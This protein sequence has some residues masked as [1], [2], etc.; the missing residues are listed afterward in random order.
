MSSG[1]G[2]ADHF[3]SDSTAKDTTEI[4][5]TRT[6]PTFQ[7]SQTY[8]GESISS[9]TGSSLEP[10]S[11][12]RGNLVSQ[13]SSSA[14]HDMSPSS[15][16][17]SART[18]GSLLVRA[19]SSTA[20]LFI[21]RSPSE[22][23][24]N[25]RTNRPVMM[26]IGRSTS[27]RDLYGST[28]FGDTDKR[29]FYDDFT[30]VDWVHDTIN[31]SSR[32][33]YLQ[34]LDGLR[35]KVIRSMDGLQ[36]WV[37]IVIVAFAFSLIAYFIDTFDARF[38]DLKTGYCSANPFNDLQTCCPGNDSASSCAA[39]VTWSEVFEGTAT[40]DI[41]AVD[42]LV[43]IA[44][45][46]IFAYV[47]V[48]LTL[49]TKT[50]NPLSEG[51]DKNLASSSTTTSHLT[52]TT[53]SQHHVKRPLEE[54]SLLNKEK[55]V[56]YSAYGSG[57]PEVKII[58]S[59]FIIRKFLGTRT[60]IIKTIALVFAISSGL[61]IGKE[62]PYVHLATCVGNIA[63][64]I[65]PKF[66][67]NDI[68]RR[69]ILAAAS[70]AGVALAFGSP[71]GGVLFSLEEVAYHFLPNHLFR[72][73]FCAMMSA[74]F[75]K[76]WDPYK[77]GKI[78]MFE[79]AYPQEWR[80]WELSLYI[81]LGICGG[82]Y[83]ALFCKFTLWWPKV[84]RTWKPIKKSPKLEVLLIT[85]ITAIVCFFNPYTK[86]SVTEL[87][88]DL[89]A[90]CTKDSPS[91]Q[92][93]PTDVKAIPSLILVLGSALFVKAILTAI[94]FGVKV[95]S[96]IYVPS[97]V[98]G[99]LFGR[100]L[101]LTIQYMTY[102]KFSS[103]GYDPEFPVTAGTYAMAGAGAFLAGV[104]RMNITLAVIL[105]EITGSLGHV[106]PFSIAILVANWIANAI[107]PHNLYELMIYEKNFPYLDNRRTKAFDN[108]LADLVTKI[109]PDEQIDLTNDTYINSV[110]LQ[111]IVSN[112]QAR[113]D[114][115]G[116]IPLV[117]KGTLV[118]AIS[119]P[120]LEY[121]L[122]HLAQLCVE[123]GYEESILC[124][125]SVLDSD[126]N[127]FHKYYGGQS[128]DSDGDGVDIDFSR[129]RHSGGIVTWYNDGIDDESSSDL[130]APDENLRVLKAA[131][132]FTRYIDRAPIMLDIHSPMALVNMIF[133][134][135]GAR[136]VFA[137]SDGKLVGILHRK[138]YIDF[139][140]K[141]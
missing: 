84:F 12:P 91:L 137:V 78:V 62:G 129:R 113:G 60:L 48:S 118:G 22:V 115:D 65:F 127:K 72:I 138:K 47:A 16:R 30:T 132:D 29:S 79:V 89:A 61:S 66:K 117:K 112:L 99:A 85:I 97:M 69:Q 76:F 102:K 18:L 26:D 139:C 74:L 119:T 21:P 5:I 25:L 52:S 75:L 43:Y 106:L 3:V 128:R 64:R 4:T 88:L 130:L 90:P 10:Q 28:T 27:F 41:I 71:L 121:A 100:V 114:F 122:D 101:A 59:G 136:V 131:S 109:S 57:V 20:E 140:R 50:V 35:G 135:L 2:S 82:L 33:K 133:S 103:M 13:L 116:C 7:R 94:T 81:F 44:L 14:I 36:G 83:G 63:C 55:R 110:H 11:S 95:P 107:E 31:E 134:K 37:L 68:K 32:R 23:H 124:K 9:R 86:K 56:F 17:L 38:S 80:L 34:S 141:Y 105:F 19:K 49:M 73:F 51:R 70:A 93:C 6:K 53:S 8:N 58:L 125:I 111:S 96:G 123:F 54:D 24:T 1:S 108:S 92:L 46:V 126:I 40:T 45:S 15:N 98:V 67:E 120:E 87:L 104:T 42:F 39:W 77:T